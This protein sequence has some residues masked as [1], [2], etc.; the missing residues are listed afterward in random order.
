MSNNKLSLFTYTQPDLMAGL[1]QNTRNDSAGNPVG[2]TLSLA[3]R[4]EVAK[5]F[6]LQ[7]K[8]QACT[9]KLVE[10]SDAMKQATAAEFMK[11]AAS[12]DWTGAG[13]SVRVGKNGVQRVTARLV[14]IKRESKTITPEQLAEA[15]AKMDPAA[16]AEFFAKATK[17]AKPAVNL[18]PVP[19]S[20]AAPAPEAPA[21][22]VESEVEPEPAPENPHV[23]EMTDEEL[24]AATAPANS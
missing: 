16:Q 15:I 24:E 17:L 2:I 4:K 22:N 13:M 9:D 11:L 12:N 20:P 1:V 3:K 10:L 5:A 14:S 7:A 6:G 21:V 23:N 19:E 8:G 18:P